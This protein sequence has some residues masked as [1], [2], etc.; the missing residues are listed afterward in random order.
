MCFAVAAAPGDWASD[1]N[2]QAPSAGLNSIHLEAPIDS[3]V[4]WSWAK[5]KADSGGR[6]RSAFLVEDSPCYSRE[7]KQDDHGAGW[8]PLEQHF[9]AE[10][11]THFSYRE[12]V[13][14]LAIQAADPGLAVR[15]RPPL[16]QDGLLVVQHPDADSRDRR[17]VGAP[18]DCHHDIR[19]FVTATTGRRD[20]TREPD[21]EKGDHRGRA[22]QGA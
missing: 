12:H 13:G 5:V 1:L 19:T 17:A 21:S 20:R 14:L 18:D 8:L 11:R 15:R 4:F 9:G 2:E 22:A 7:G 10:L 16:P 3:R 6:D